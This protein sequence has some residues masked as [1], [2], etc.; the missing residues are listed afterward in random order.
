MKPRSR[1]W[2]SS[3]YAEHAVV[4]RD[5]DVVWSSSA[6][7]VSTAA[8][9]GGGRADSSVA[10]DRSNSASIDAGSAGFSVKP[11]P[12]ASVRDFERADAV[13]EPVELLAQARFGAGAARRRQQHVERLVELHPGAIEV[14]DLELAL[15]RLDSASAIRR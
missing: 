12:S 5:R 9:S 14:A 4:E 7:S 1:P 6:R 11:S 15:A 13:D 10:G 2:K 3:T 8:A